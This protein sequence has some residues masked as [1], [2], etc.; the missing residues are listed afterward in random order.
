MRG[1]FA[2]ALGLIVLQTVLSKAAAAD[3]VAGGLTGIAGLVDSAVN[4]T[5]PLIWDRQP[6]AKKSHQSLGSKIGSSV[7]GGIGGF[8]GD[9]AG[10]VVG[11]IPGVPGALG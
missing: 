9:L 2:A 7:G 8:F 10:K 3:R 4:P 1:F 6:N 11:A 5:V